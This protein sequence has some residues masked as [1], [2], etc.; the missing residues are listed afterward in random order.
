MND[1][2]LQA[3]L[4]T[5]N[6]YSPDAVIANPA[7]NACFLAV[8]RELGA[9][10]TD[11][12]LNHCLYNLRKSK[13]LDGHP[14]KTRVHLKRKDEYEFAAEIAARFLEHREN[15]TLDRIICDPVLA[16]EFDRIAQ[17]L[18]PGFTPFEY[19]FAALNLRKSHRL[20]PEIGPQLL[21]ATQVESFPVAGLDINRI[22]R[23]QGIYLFYYKGEGL[24]YLGEAMNLRDRIRKH[25]DHSDRKE[26]ARWLW[27]HGSDDLYVEIHVLPDKTT[28]GARKAVELELIRSRKPRF[29]ILGVEEGV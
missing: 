14:T 13:K 22:P 4:R 29:N 18:A 19:R 10:E 26:L 24:L 23:S 25:L 2:V 15:T 17:E 7:L 21:P 12:E 8:C 5:R 28:T 27:Q 6:G 9:G 11:F 16:Q 3:F 1:Q 20:R